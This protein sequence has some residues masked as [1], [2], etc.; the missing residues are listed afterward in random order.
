MPV[1]RNRSYA[2]FLF[3]M[4]GTMLDS[5]AAVDRVW[6]AWA[7]RHGIDPATLLATVHG[8]R[9]SDTIRRFAGTTVDIAKETQ[10]I[11]EAEVRDVDGVVALEGIHVFIEALEPGTWAI[12]TSAP[13]A[14]AEVRLRAARL[15]IPAVMITAE[16]VQ[17]GKPDPQ[18]FLLGAQRLGVNIGECLV[19]EDSPAGVAAAKAA[20]AHVA[21]VGGLVPGAEGNFVLANY[22]A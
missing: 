14:L 21:I 7:T 16:D 4:D 10:W 6:G 17:R 3:D 22:S 11:L 20:G 19:F 2:A 1:F 8:V 12:V 13:R 9:S 15:P 18:G 5:S